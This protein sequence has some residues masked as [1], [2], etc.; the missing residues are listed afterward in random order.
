MKGLKVIISIE[1]EIERIA[2]EG[3]K[4]MER[5]NTLKWVLEL[6]G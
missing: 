3:Y 4:E 5:Y 2:A 1:K 6:A